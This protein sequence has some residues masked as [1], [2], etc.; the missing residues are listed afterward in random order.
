MHH[1]VIITLIVTSL[2]ATNLSK[3]DENQ[4]IIIE[5]ILIITNYLAIQKAKHRFLVH[6]YALSKK[7]KKTSQ[8]IIVAL[9]LRIINNRG[10]D[11]SLSHL[12]YH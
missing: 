2:E 4:T 9:R 8:S 11:D 10:T 3:M 1:S 6:D 7:K 12:R 5:H